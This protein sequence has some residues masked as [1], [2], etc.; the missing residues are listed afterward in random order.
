MIN[1]TPSI[2][3]QFHMYEIEVGVGRPTN[4]LSVIVIAVCLF[5]S[6]VFII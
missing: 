1:I 4:I 6:C 3:P 2:D 5:L